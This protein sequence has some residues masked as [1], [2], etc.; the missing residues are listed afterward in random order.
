MKHTLGVGLV[1][2]LVVYLGLASSA[3]LRADDDKGTRVTIDGLTSMAPADWKEE[4]VSERARN[5]GRV[6]QFKL[7]RAKGDKHHG[8]L[9]IFSFMGGG[10]V[11]A[12]VE[13]WQGM[14]IPPKGKKIDDVTKVEKTKVGK[15][16]VVFV[17]IHGTFKYSKAPFA[18]N[19]KK[20]LRPDYRQVNVIFEGKD[21]TYFFRLTGPAK[22]IARYKKGFDTFVKSF[23]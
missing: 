3:G 19:V 15:V 9:V 10:S 16:P 21:A 6:K 8:E 17:D 23:K 22:T 12:N 14:F 7:P 18:P 13:R 20:E 4:E 2:C 1:G 5:F 11:K